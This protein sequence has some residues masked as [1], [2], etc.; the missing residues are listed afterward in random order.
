MYLHQLSKHSQ[1]ASS[2]LG[3]QGKSQVLLGG[4]EKRKTW[5][6]TSL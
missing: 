6:L 3:R 5:S 4:S 2:T 1:K